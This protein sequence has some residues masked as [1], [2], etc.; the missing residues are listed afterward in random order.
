M[1]SMDKINMKRKVLIIVA[2]ILAIIAIVI[3]A[4]SFYSKGNGGS[5]LDSIREFIPFGNPPT[6]DDGSAVRPLGTETEDARNFIEEIPSIRLIWADPTAGF[7]IYSDQ[8]TTTKSI[9]RFVDRATGHVYGADTDSL[10]ARRL[11]NT[12][13]PKIMEALRDNSDENSFI[14]RYLRESGD[15][16]ETVFVKIKKREG[17]KT[18]ELSSEFESELTFLKRNI[19]SIS[20]KNTGGDI[21]Y[22]EKPTGSRTLI[23]KSKNDGGGESVLYDSP[24]QEIV[25]NW[26]SPNRISVMTKSSSLSSGFLYFLNISN[27]KL[28]KV[29]GPIGSLNALVNPDGSNVIYSTTNSGV[30]STFGRNLDSNE[31][32]GIPIATLPRDKC[33]WSDNQNT[34]VYCGVFLPSNSTSFPDKWYQGV[35]SL[36]DS[37]WEIDVETG[38]VLIIVDFSDEIGEEVDIIKPQLSPDDGYIFFIN[39]K[40]GS[41]WSVDLNK[42]Y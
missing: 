38:K 15:E 39:K 5:S 12:T 25:L 2:I 23:K 20:T 13:M 4:L 34:K 28:E 40:N 9:I 36:N 42:E 3:W 6:L 27:N 21:T 35:V 33:V 24:I 22:V 17:G 11:V 26:F 7:G 19:V 41:L 31:G 10:E 37:L 29:I 32:V 30:T 1:W 18:E 16:I 8:S 14:A